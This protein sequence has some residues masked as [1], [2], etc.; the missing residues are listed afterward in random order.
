MFVDFVQGMGN[1]NMAKLDSYSLKL[2]ILKRIQ[3]ST[4]N[5][6]IKS[7][8]LER[9]YR[10]SSE[11]IREVVRYWRRSHKP[12]GS[13]RN[14]YYWCRTYGEYKP[15]IE[16]LINRRNSLDKTIRAMQSSFDTSG[17]QQSMFIDTKKPTTNY[18]TGD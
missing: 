17:G 5:M 14:G 1:I 15:T 11:Q 4:V 13:G 18:D 10:L 16:N 9:E 12:I 8:T 2:D 7:S 3:S 6:P